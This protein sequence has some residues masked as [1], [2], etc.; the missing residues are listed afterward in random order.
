MWYDYKITWDWIMNTTL[1][2]PGGIDF[3]I[4]HRFFLRLHWAD[5]IIPIVAQVSDMTNGP[6]V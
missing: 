6:L 4:V 3:Y 2:Y 5:F 1:E